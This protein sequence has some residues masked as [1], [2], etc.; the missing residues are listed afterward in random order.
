VD[1]G[2]REGVPNRKQS[3][4]SSSPHPP[5]HHHNRA[6]VPVALVYI[7]LYSATFV[8]IKVGL[9]YCPPMT[10][11]SVRF[12]AA[13]AVTAL[14][15]RAA[16][17]GWPVTRRS[18]L[19]LIALG[20]VNTMVP[21]TFNFFALHEISVGM[22]AIIVSLNPLILT[23]LAPQLLG[24]RLSGLRLLGLL[25]GFGGV[26]FVMAVRVGANRPDTPLGVLLLLG[27]T[28][29]M[30]AGTLLFKRFPPREH[31]LM[32]NTV[33]HLVA[34]AAL[35]PLLLLIEKPS[36]TV[37][38][39]PLIGALGYMVLC[40]S[41]GATLLWFWLLVRG[42]ASVASSFYFLSPIFGIALGA[43]FFHEPFGWR[44]ALGLV[45]IC[46]GIFMIRRTGKTAPIAISSSK[47]KPTP[48]A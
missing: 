13:G 29:S 4:V 38:S 16:G 9:K 39:V 21:A 36:S 46:V 15:A 24:E 26:V 30:A 2:R 45:V 10:L 27:G 31:L 48:G 8:S 35:I 23:L 12:L 33:Q 17:A 7:T 11:L 22:A 19:R 42:E 5:A 44:E 3:A 20:I 18:W 1:R 28:I 25:L 6:V 37:V 14:I 40:T 43:A 47:S 41:V 32:V 34:G